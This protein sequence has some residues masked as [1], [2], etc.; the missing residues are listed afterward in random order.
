MNYKYDS[1][2]EEMYITSLIKSFKKTLTDGFFSF[3]IVD[4]INDQH[5]HFRDML[6]QAKQCGFMVTIYDFI[7]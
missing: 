7:F 4:A 3:I 6:V 1:S 2:M 5:H